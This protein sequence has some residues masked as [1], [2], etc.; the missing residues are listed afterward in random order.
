MVILYL[1]SLDHFHSIGNQEEWL[2]V[3]SAFWHGDLKPIYAQ[4][5]VPSTESSCMLTDS[6]TL[7]TY[8][9]P[10]GSCR[11]SVRYSHWMWP[12]DLRCYQCYLVSSR[13]TYYCWL[14][15]F[16]LPNNQTSLMLIMA[17]P[18]PSPVCLIL[19]YC[20]DCQRLG[21]LTHPVSVGHGSAHPL[22][23]CHLT[24]L[25]CCESVS[26]QATGQNCQRQIGMAG[27]IWGEKRKETWKWMTLPYS[28]RVC[29]GMKFVGYPPV[30]PFSVDGI[31]PK[32]IPVCCTLHVGEWCD[33]AHC[34]WHP[35]RERR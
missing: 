11:C 32:I 22:C 12:L 27:F 33:L 3:H 17:D 9:P 7:S 31:S 1:V 26:G 10:I 19:E 21:H 16:S 6:H 20:V 15:L 30:V 35:S 29:S 5:I 24:V 14:L 8:R 18:N 28:P 13:D 4:G 25:S 34:I 23:R 2:L